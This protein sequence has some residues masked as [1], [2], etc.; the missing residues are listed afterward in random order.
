MNRAQKILKFAA[1]FLLIV[2]GTAT[3][4]S[5][6]AA[7]IRVC[8][9]S[10]TIT[11]ASNIEPRWDWVVDTLLYAIA[12]FICGAVTFIGG[13]LQ[14]RALRRHAQTAV[15]GNAGETSVL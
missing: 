14:F 5:G 6:I 2:A 13:L 9:W 10:L 15:P 8:S 7:V 12:F 11:F 3:F 1:A 4:Y